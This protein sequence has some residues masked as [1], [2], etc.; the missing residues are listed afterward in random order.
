MRAFIAI[1]PPDALR[2]AFAAAQQE[3]AASGAD[4]A[5]VAPANL[6]VTLKFL[7]DITEPQRE[8]ISR[9][10]QAIAT[11]TAP[12]T[13]QAVGVGAFPSAHAPRVVWVGLEDA[14]GQLARMAALIEREA[15]ILT[16]PSEEH[17][18]SA[19]VTLGRVRS[20]RGRTA[21]AERLG[22]AVFRHA[23][24]W[25]VTSVTLYQSH[26]SG[27]GARYTVLADLPLTGR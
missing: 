14:E 8:A 22:S 18:F 27:A 5:W 2:F 11:L 10:L 21:L 6:H 25:P 12:F 1:T 24:A 4:V 23:A 17:S 9:T 26:L 19:H 13:L 7:G 15:R 3:L 16:L 20:S